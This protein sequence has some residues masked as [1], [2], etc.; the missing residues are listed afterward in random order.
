[1][2]KCEQKSKPAISDGTFYFLDENDK[3]HIRI[4]RFHGRQRTLQRLIFVVPASMFE[5]AATLKAWIDYTAVQSASIL[6]VA[7]TIVCTLAT[8]AAVLI[9]FIM[10]H[11]DSSDM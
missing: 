8:F 6:L 1:M 3:D 10:W 4:R 2:A 5:V 7:T 11:K 9:P